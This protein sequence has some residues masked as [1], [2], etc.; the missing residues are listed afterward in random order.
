MERRSD[1]LGLARRCLEVGLAGFVLK[2]H[3]VTT[4]ERAEVVRNA[5]PG[6]DALGAITLNGSMGGMNPRCCERLREAQ[7]AQGWRPPDGV[8]VHVGAQPIVKV[9]RDQRVRFDSGHDDGGIVDRCQQ[10]ELDEA[11]GLSGS[12][13]SPARAHVTAWRGGQRWST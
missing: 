1:D 10:S 9:V 13:S 4:A 2:S 6:V 12:V 7:P 8:G 5:V 11:R 3:Y